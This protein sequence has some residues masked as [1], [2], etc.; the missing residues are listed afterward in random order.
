MQSMK[1]SNDI[2]VWPI[3]HAY[4]LLDKIKRSERERNRKKNGTERKNS[5][6][7]ERYGKSKCHK[8]KMLICNVI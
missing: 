6:K 4:H 2:S 8:R 5:N 1:Y 3:E 7:H